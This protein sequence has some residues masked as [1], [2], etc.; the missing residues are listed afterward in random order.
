MSDHS[1]K[2]SISST[3][4]YKDIQW[5]S[6]QRQ[7]KSIADIASECG[8]AKTTIRKYLKRFCIESRSISEAMKIKYTDSEHMQKRKQ[9]WNS[10]EYK[11]KQR[12]IAEKNKDL[13][14]KITKKLWDNDEYVK[15]CTSNHK[16]AMVDPEVRNRMSHGVKN[17]WKDAE[18]IAKQLA[19]SDVRSAKFSETMLGLWQDQQYRENKIEQNR[20]N[21][22]NR[23]LTTNEFIQRAIE[24][25]GNHF[26][27]D[28]SEYINYDRN[29]IDII[30]NNCGH[31]F[32][33]LAGGHLK[34]A[35]CPYCHTSTGQ[36]EIYDF[37]SQI[38]ETHLNDRDQIKPLEIDIWIPS[39]KIG[40]EYHGL[41]WHSWATTETK[42]QRELHQR[43]AMLCLSSGI[44]LL[45][46]WDYQWTEK[47]EIVKSIIANKLGL[48]A[49]IA[50]RKSECMVLSHDTASAFFNNNHLYGFRPAANYLGLI[51]NGEI[52]MAMSVASNGEVI[53]LA[54]KC[55][56]VVVGGL[57]KLCVFSKKMG[58][59]R[60]SSYV[61]LNFANGLGYVSAGF[62]LVGVTKPGYFYYK[63]V[64][65]LS[66]QQCQ[67]NKLSRLLGEGFDPDQSESVNMFVNGFR[68]VWDSGNLKFIYE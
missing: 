48:S 42:Q 17:K 26:N 67:K 30:C 62:K 47:Q 12:E 59:S 60:L 16:K 19:M 5:L 3:N 15:L 20:I 35:T 57:S 64:R 8:V 11:T 14:S 33:Q 55:G 31:K 10:D 13:K 65:R 66:R 24:A 23:R 46:F 41:R 9:Q 28:Q 4:T 53:R 50:A 29:K 63:G 34:G 7:T 61:D 22:E 27:Y 54:S 32:A 40:I 49:K 58:I 39:Y 21:G 36:R 52:V 38:T 45:Q 18:Y 68:R 1:D 25:N 51:N 37:V 43:K 44:S 56:Y 2:S 6:E